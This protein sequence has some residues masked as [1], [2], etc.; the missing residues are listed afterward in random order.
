MSQPFPIKSLQG[1]LVKIAATVPRRAALRD[2]PIVALAYDLTL[3]YLLL[4]PTLKKPRIFHSGHHL[5]KGRATLPN[6]LFV[7]SLSN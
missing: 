2:D 5:V 3:D 1:S 7:Q 4:V 6:A